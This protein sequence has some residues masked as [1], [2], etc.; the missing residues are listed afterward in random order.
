MAAG[1]L[2]PT[3]LLSHSSGG[4]PSGS[5]E[6]VACELVASCPNLDVSIGG[7]VVSCL[8]DTGSMVSTMTESLF[9]EQFAPW[10]QDRLRSCNWLQLQ[11]ANGLAILYIGYLE[12]DVELCGKV[13]PHC[14]VLVVRDP[15][16]AVSFPWHLGDECYS[17]PKIGRALQIGRAHV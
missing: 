6:G 2:A 12:L 11:A 9:M 13:M 5:Q 16:G 14:G 4:E 7:V 17:S 1:K 3:E 15:P 10:G 8:V